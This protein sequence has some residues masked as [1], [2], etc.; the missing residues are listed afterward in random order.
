MKSLKTYAYM[1]RRHAVSRL[2]FVL[3][4]WVCLSGSFMFG[5]G[6]KEEEA[7]A[8]AEKSPIKVN[9]SGAP[10]A[11]AKNIEAHLPSLRN[12]KCTADQARLDRFIDAATDKLIEGADAMG[13]FSAKF[14]TTAQRQGGCWVLNVAVTPGK[15]VR[16][17]EINIEI[18]G[19]GRELRDFREINAKW[20]YK[21]GDV[22]VTQPYEDF[23]SSLSSAASRLGFF[24]A[25]FKKRRIK[26]EIEASVADVELQFDTGKRY[27]IGRMT[28]RQNV[29]DEKHFRRYLRIKPGQTYDS[30][31]LLEQRRLLEASG[32]YKDV[33]INTQFDQAK[34]LRVP[35]NITAVRRKRYTYTGNLGY[36]T[37]T[38][39]R[40]ET[41][42]E[43]HWVNERGHK[44]DA[45]VRLSQNDPAATLRYK[46]PLWNPEH[47]FASFAVDWSRSDND[48]IRG[49][50][51]ELKFDYNRRNKN[52][53]QQT[54]YV[55]LLNEK[56]QVQGSPAT[57]S[58]LALLGGRVNKTVK[59]DALFPTSGWRLQAELKGA[60]DSV[61]SD[62]S[63]LQGIV[64][65]K[66]LYTFPS[67]NKLLLRGEFGA[68]LTN[69]FNEL[70]KSLR[71]F[72][73]GQN[74]VR[75]HDFET[76]GERDAAGN[77]VGGK[78]LIVASAEY[79]R[80]F[81]EKISGAVF[82]DAGSAFDEWGDFGFEVGV[83]IGA[84]YKS[85]LG[86][87][88]VDFAIPD[89][90]PGDLHFYFSLGPD[91]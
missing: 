51:F 11:L 23:K 21:K 40:L 48:D 79:E 78:N 76:I 52:D 80:P 22:L 47:E 32:Y 81:T 27:Q 43:T 30:D 88:R 25:E 84:R 29:L 44:L 73:G 65:G 71:F 35:V 62:V 9:V 67:K 24:D 3:L 60:H 2:I 77:V 39:A 33:Q 28:I 19:D 34:G 46:V 10:E 61:L 45:K 42:V 59:D 1:F 8:E 12:L 89:D 90:D 20:P 87:I 38:G 70:P 68:S 49:D 75:G 17:R 26:V 86:P 50:K 16:V 6:D 91:L 7:L 53:W 37:D 83:G 13:Y 5:G 15:P 72:A 85:P 57:T 64:D 56:T 66:Y 41:G 31:V 14:K 58:Q 82:V 55:S 69:E 4:A 74:S 36:A 63:V 18:V 54:A